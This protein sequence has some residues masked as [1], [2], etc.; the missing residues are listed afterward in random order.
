[1]THDNGAPFPLTS[2]SSCGVELPIV[3]ITEHY[4]M[5]IRLLHSLWSLIA[6]FRLRP[7]GEPSQRPLSL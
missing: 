3:D 5:K 6:I 7:A 1:M 4:G 2:G